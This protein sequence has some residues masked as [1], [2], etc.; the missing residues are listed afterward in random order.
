MR[1]I[2]D[3]SVLIAG[4]L[5]DSTVRRLL[6]DPA[7]QLCLPEHALEE[8]H[9]HAPLMRRRARLSPHAFDLLVVLLTAQVE[10]IPAATVRPW[11]SKAHRLLGA[12]D[13][14]DVPFLAA[15]YAVPCDGLWS[16]DADFQVVHDVPIW[17]T[18][19]LLKHLGF[20]S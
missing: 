17:T 2:L 7:L 8:V 6:L 1:L 9:R 10:V 16:D 5:K 4:L 19:R 3:T 11:L 20:A 15:A 14:D 12:R 18:S 13:P